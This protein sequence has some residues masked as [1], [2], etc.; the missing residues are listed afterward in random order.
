MYLRTILIILIL[1]VLVFFAAINWGAFMSPTTLSVGFTSIEAPLGLILLGITGVLTLLF[2]IY[3]V[4][5]QSSA[6]MESRR[7][8]RELQSQR[9]MAE[10][11]EA[12]RFKELQ[13]FLDVE[14]RQI[15]NR[16]VESGGAILKRLDERER[17]LR[18]AV[19]QSGNTLAA[20]IGEIDDRLE[21]S[22]G[23]KVPD[24]NR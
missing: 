1:G 2:L 22:S 21:R 9:E 11:A 12:S 18:S 20:Y 13:S 4:Y 23:A 5:L 3:V 10:N 14:L 19:E 17:D 15:A 8:A 7:Y 16:T 24:T 6:L